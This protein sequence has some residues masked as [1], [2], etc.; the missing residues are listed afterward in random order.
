MPDE[1]LLREINIELAE[2]ER[3]FALRMLAIRKK[4]KLALGDVRQ[5]PPVIEFVS[6]DGKTR[7]INRRPK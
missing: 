1:T 2:V 6:P 4:L 3:D 5:R 7:P